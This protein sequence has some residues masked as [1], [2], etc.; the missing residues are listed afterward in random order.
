[1]AGEKGRHESQFSWQEIYV[2]LCA[3]ARLRLIIPTHG[4]VSIYI[5]LEN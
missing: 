1:V 5:Q 2:D 3:C 4:Y